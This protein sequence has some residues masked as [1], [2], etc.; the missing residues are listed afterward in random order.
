[1]AGRFDRPKQGFHQIAMHQPDL[2]YVDAYGLGECHHCQLIPGHLRVTRI[3]QLDNPISSL[4]EGGNREPVTLREHGKFE[5]NPRQ[6]EG[7]EQVRRAASLGDRNVFSS[8]SSRSKL[9]RG[10]VSSRRVSAI[11]SMRSLTTCSMHCCRPS[12]KAVLSPCARV[13]TN[14]SSSACESK[15]SCSS[16]SRPNCPAGGERTWAYQCRAPEPSAQQDA[17]TRLRFREVG[18]EAGQHHEKV[19]VRQEGK[20]GH[21]GV[22]LQECSSPRQRKLPLAVDFFRRFGPEVTSLARA[23]RELDPDVAGHVSPAPRQHGSQHRVVIH[24]AKAPFIVN[25]F[26]NPLEVGK[27]LHAA[28]RIGCSAENTS[29]RLSRL[30]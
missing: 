4:A 14:S 12:W 6:G 25:G 26:R 27:R 20:M 15:R 19:A 16:T 2:G 24:D 10:D 18:K 9:S 30:P 1:M 17:V 7:P 21:A 23:F 8:L 22:L 13:L 5:R 3:G 29:A 28:V 11:R